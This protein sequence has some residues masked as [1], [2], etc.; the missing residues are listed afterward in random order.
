M[1]IAPISSKPIVNVVLSRGGE[2]RLELVTEDGE[3]WELRINNG[4]LMIVKSA[5][6]KPKE[7]K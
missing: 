2:N 5:D 3:H 7:P 4:E 6:Q 1:T